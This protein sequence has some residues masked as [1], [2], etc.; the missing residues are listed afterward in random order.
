MRHSTVLKLV[1]KGEKERCSGR[2]EREVWDGDFGR[3]D[4]TE[5]RRAKTD[6]KFKLG[7]LL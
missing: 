6:R 3:G 2:A 1:K 7:T 4:G 5:L